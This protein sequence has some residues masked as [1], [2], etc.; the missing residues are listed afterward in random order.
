MC[1]HRRRPTCPRSKHCRAWRRYQFSVP[2]S[3]PNVRQ[4]IVGFI[5][6]GVLTFT[7]SYT[8]LWLRRISSNPISQTSILRRLTPRTVKDPAHFWISILTDLVFQLS[9]QQL[10]IGLLLLVCAYVKYW[11]SSVIHGGDNL[12]TATDIVCFSSFTHA[13][14]LLTLRPYFR[15]HRRIATARVT[16]MYLIF[17][18]WLIVAGQILAPD[19]PKDS[20]KKPKL[21]SDFWHAATVIEAFGIMWVYLITY[22]PIFLSEDATRIRTIISEGSR[23]DIEVVRTWIL[24]HQ[25][26][27]STHTISRAAW[28]RYNPYAVARRYLTQWAV[29]F[30]NS[31]VKAESRR[32]RWGLWVAAELLMPW[33]T[34]GIILGVLWVFSLGALILSLYQNGLASSWDFGQ[35]LPAFMILLPFQSLVGALTGTL[36]YRS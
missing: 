4:V 28:K 10:V 1:L 24:R 5:L 33:Y 17:A 12:W 20:E 25:R 32:Q 18:L 29:H 9:D 8:T 15:L 7:F 30:G 23:G 22:L 3:A 31:F 14:T 6:T 11:P 19:K 26:R 35:L 2:T 21:I 16:I 27:W 34:T 13:A 36:P